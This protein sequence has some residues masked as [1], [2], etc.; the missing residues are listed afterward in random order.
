MQPSLLIRRHSNQFHTEFFLPRPADDG[1][2][3]S[4]RFSNEIDPYPD[5]VSLVHGHRAS[6]AASFQG[7]IDHQST[8]CLFAEEHGRQ[9]DGNPRALSFLQGTPFLV[10]VLD[11]VDISFEACDCSAPGGPGRRRSYVSRHCPVPV[12][13]IPRAAYRASTTLRGTCNRARLY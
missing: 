8:A 1:K 6:D 2:V 4:Q 11:E 10:H 7:Y 9:H 13:L 3:P 12:K 5:I